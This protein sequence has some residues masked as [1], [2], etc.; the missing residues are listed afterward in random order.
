[1]VS[2]SEGAVLHQPG[3]AFALVSGLD[4]LGNAKLLQFP[5]AGVH[6]INLPNLRLL[7]LKRT[8]VTKKGAKTIQQAIGC[9]VR[10]LAHLE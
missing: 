9:R 3:T 5:D 4:D 8:Q 2:L 10:H 6:L 7:S 1:M